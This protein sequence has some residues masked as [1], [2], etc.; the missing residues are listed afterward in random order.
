M[1]VAT[2]AL[3]KAF[4][5][6]Y[7]YDNIADSWVVA[8]EAYV[9]AASTGRATLFRA[10]EE[11]AISLST[12]FDVDE[13]HGWGRYLRGGVEV[14]VCPGNHTSMCEEPHVQVLAAKLRASLVR[15]ARFPLGG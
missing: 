6:R 9:P 10:A 4:P 3:G 11:T 5:E 12:A 2:R 8:E 7:R 14:E 13:R 15:A 1:R